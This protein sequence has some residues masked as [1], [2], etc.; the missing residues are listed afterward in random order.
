MMRSMTG[1]GQA[2]RNIGGAQCVV[3]VRSLNSRYFKATVRLPELWSAYEADIEKHVRDRLRRGAVHLTMRMKTTS[4]DMAH[5]VNTDVLERYVEQLDTVR[6][7]QT[8]VAM[9]MDLASLLLLP[10]VCSP[11]ELQEMV[12]GARAELM[13]L[14]DEAIAGLLAM[15]AEEGK[16]IDADLEDQCRL[17]EER[18]KQIAQRAPQVLKDYHQRLKRRVA[19]LTGSAELA[20]DEQ[21]LARE[22]AIY[23][24]RCDIAEELLRL[25]SHLGQFRSTMRSEDQPGRKLDFIA[26]EM[27]REANTIAAKGNDAEITRAIVDVK[28]AIDRIKEQV[29]NV[30]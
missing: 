16:A 20:L 21:E 9:S 4:P 12:E 17:I 25:E 30:E 7:D 29:Q 10:G 1:F 27:L 19:E 26:Q 5:Q 28:S 18:G 13:K 11:P 15:R 24:E 3:E 23:A 8:D 2:Q 14:V 22:V 6:P